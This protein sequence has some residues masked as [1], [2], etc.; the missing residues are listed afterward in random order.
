MTVWANRSDEKR[1]VVIWSPRRHDPTRQMWRDF[2]VFAVKN[3]HGRRPG[4][5]SWIARLREEKILSQKERIT[6]SIAAVKYGDK[7]FFITDIWGDELVFH[8]DLLTALG[9]IWND[10]IEDEIKNCDTAAFYIASLSESLKKAAG[11]SG[12]ISSDD[13]KAAFYAAIDAPF[14]EWLYTLSPSQSP[15]ERDQLITQWRDTAEQIAKD[16]AQELID[17]AG[18]AAFMGRTLNEREKGKEVARHYSAPEAMNLFLYR[19]KKL[20]HSEVK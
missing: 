8:I 20:Y 14:R 16:M 6:F 3:V 15:R 4:I 19:I 11:N 12:D 7:D 18:P 9:H 10:F 13:V 17:V 1:G 5:V 2:A